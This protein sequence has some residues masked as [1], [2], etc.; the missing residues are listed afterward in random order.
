VDLLL[1]SLSQC[2]SPAAITDFLNLSRDPLGNTA[3]HVAARRGALE[4]L[5]VIL[6]QEG[7]EVEPRSR[8]EGDTP[9]HSA[10]RLGSNDG[11]E[12][13]AVEVAEMLLEAGADPRYDG[14]G[15]GG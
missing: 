8:R 6:D 7:V 4:T 9:L 15:N 14:L 2:S 12:A 13:V 10:A 11:E 5:D 1:E 3:L